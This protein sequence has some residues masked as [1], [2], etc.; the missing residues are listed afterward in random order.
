M[1]TGNLR[2]QFEEDFAKGYIV[3][4]YR[5]RSKRLKFLCLLLQKR[6]VHFSFGNC[7]FLTIDFLEKIFRENEL[8]LKITKILPI[9]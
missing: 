7:F 5:V 4:N 3:S 6:Q 9:F 2:E 1:V 8:K